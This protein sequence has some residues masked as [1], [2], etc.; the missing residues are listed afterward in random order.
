MA[1]PRKLTDEEMAAAQI[2]RRAGAPWKAICS[3]FNI[4][5]ETARLVVGKMPNNPES[6]VSGH[7]NDS[8]PPQFVAHI[9]GQST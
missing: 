9:V 2:M 3:R 6:E 1:R 4:C 8:K 7:K 5:R